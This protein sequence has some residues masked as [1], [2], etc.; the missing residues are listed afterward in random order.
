MGRREPS[1]A[2]RRRRK[3]RPV[4]LTALIERI[5]RQED[6]WIVVV[7]CPYCHEQHQH[8][9]GSGPTPCFGH[10]LS[11]CQGFEGGGYLLLLPADDEAIP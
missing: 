1:R 4:S 5:D 6:V 8:G 9:G 3:R 7:R 10:R 11:H 2:G